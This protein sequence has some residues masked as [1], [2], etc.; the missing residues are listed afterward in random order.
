MIRRTLLVISAVA[1]VAACNNDKKTAAKGDDTA[2]GPQASDSADEVVVPA[3]PDFSKWQPE[4]KQA[5][6]QGSWLVKN[7]GTIVAWTVDG[8]KVTTWDGETENKLTLEITAPCRA[9][10]K[11]DKGFSYPRNFTVVGGALQYRGGGAG[12]RDGADAIYC[13]AS[14]AIY[15]LAGGTC[16]IWEEKFGK[17]ETR[18]AECGI[19]KNAEGAE[20]F[21]HADP[22]GG[23]FEIAGNAIVSPTSFPTEK[24]D[25]DPKAARDAREAKLAK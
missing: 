5:A 23:E 15:V 17:W 4:D 11:N 10:F 2:A 7:N 20:V 8:T 21:F 24:V 25:G 1:M 18:A 22:N 3:A 6:W 9:S 14:G 13:D 12:Y 19:K 16:A